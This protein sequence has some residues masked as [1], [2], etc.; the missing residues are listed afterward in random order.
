M[1]PTRGLNSVNETN[2]WMDYFDG[3]PDVRTTMMNTT[4]IER[5]L[6]NE[7]FEDSTDLEELWATWWGTE[8]SDE[9]LLNK[10]TRRDVQE[11]DDQIKHQES[12]W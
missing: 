8:G 7:S 10:R 1:K 11:V 6:K 2:L 5:C 4:S 12:L 3:Y 9:I